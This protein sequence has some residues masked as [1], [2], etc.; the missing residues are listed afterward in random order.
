[1]NAIIKAFF[2]RKL[3]KHDPILAKAI[4]TNDQCIDAINESLNAYYIICHRG[5]VFITQ[6]MKYVALDSFRR[7]R[8]QF[9]FLYNGQT[10]EWFMQ[11]QWRT[12]MPKN[13]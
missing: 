4:P 8:N 12:L 13:M 2:N 11:T 10:D 7:E 9:G 3:V 6:S 5:D 1:M